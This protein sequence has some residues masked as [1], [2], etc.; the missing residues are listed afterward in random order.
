M[1][2]I[3]NGG[4]SFLFNVR[5]DMEEDHD[6]TNRGQSETRQLRMLLDA[7][8]SEVNAEAQSRGLR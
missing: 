1:K 3:M 8:E 2:L 6:L 4:R 7:W 5:D